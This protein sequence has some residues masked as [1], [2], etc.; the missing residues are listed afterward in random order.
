[1]MPINLRRERFTSAMLQDVG[2]FHCGDEE[3]SRDLADWIK[4]PERVLDDLAD[5]DLNCRLWVWKD[6]TGVIVG[7][8]S[9][10][11]AEFKLPNEN[12]SPREPVTIIPALAVHAAHQRK[13]YARRIL[14]ELLDIA[15][16]DADE[17]QFVVL[18]VHVDNTGAQALYSSAGFVKFGKPFV[19]KSSG[20]PHQKMYC[21]LKDRGGS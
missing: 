18:L 9:L 14:S 6:E 19:E 8:G 13:G 20:M 16:Q 12:K 10:G 5:A 15:A 21:D 4:T 2:D 17:R 7:F 1:M 11:D 3:W